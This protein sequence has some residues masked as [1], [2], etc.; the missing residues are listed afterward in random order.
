MVAGS[1]SYGSGAT[2][3]YYPY[4]VAITGS[5][6]YLIA[7]TS[8]HRVQL[9]PAQSAGSPCT[10]V[11]GS[12]SYGAGATE[13]Y[14]P[15]GVAIMGSGDYLI[16]DSSNH[17]VQRCLAASPGSPC[18]TVAGVGATSSYEEGL[19]NPVSVVHVNEDHPAPDWCASTTETQT[20]TSEHTTTATTTTP[21]TVTSVNYVEPPSDSAFGHRGAATA[22][23][24][25]V[26]S[27]AARNL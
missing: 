1:G 21:H 7:D 17:R 11:V 6:D 4:G 26:G 8:N 23:A 19:N 9:C 20:S 12:G 13:L 16:A 18:T 5:G 25:L 15:R 27:A 22:L 14:N 3:L 24:L 2:E 10:T